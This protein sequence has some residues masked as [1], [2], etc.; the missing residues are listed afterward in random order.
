MA[1]IEARL[2]KLP[3]LHSRERE[4]LETAHIALA[5]LARLQSFLQAM[6]QDGTEWQALILKIHNAIDAEVS[7]E[8]VGTPS[9]SLRDS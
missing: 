7:D 5:R 4:A 9:A 2:A 3:P 1:T 8:A 6:K